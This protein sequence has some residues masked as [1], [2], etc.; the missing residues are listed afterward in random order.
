MGL[1]TISRCRS[2]T[3]LENLGKSCNPAL[4]CHISRLQSDSKCWQSWHKRKL[5]LYWPNILSNRSQQT[6]YVCNAAMLFFRDVS[7]HTCKS[8][9]LCLNCL[10]DASL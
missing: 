6:S 3:V 8:Q 4:H 9:S 1:A 7:W 2:L 5:R 10:H